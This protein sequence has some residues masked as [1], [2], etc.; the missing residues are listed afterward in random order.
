MPMRF[1]L[2]TLFAFLS[3][4]VNADEKERIAIKYFEFLF[5]EDQSKEEVKSQLI[6][7]PLV[8]SFYSKDGHRMIVVS[9]LLSNGKSYFTLL[10]VSELNMGLLA[11]KQRGYGSSPEKDVQ[12][13]MENNGQDFDFEG[14]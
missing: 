14:W 11:W 2:L 4:Q 5:Y 6:G 1:L 3:L 12:A 7:K 9:S 8:S 10:S 13:F